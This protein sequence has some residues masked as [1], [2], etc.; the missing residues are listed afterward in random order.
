MGVPAEPRPGAAS[1]GRGLELALIATALLIGVGVAVVVV[2]PKVAPQVQFDTAA[3][4]I[5]FERLVSGERLEAFVTTTPKPFLTVLD[6]LLHRIGGW[7]AVSWMAMVG[8]G[9]AVA[10]AALLALRLGGWAA[11]GFVALALAGNAFLLVEAAYAYG[12]PWAVA[13][14]CLAGLLLASD[15]PRWGWAGAALLAAML[16]RIETVAIVAAACLVLVAVHVRRRSRWWDATSLP[17]GAWLLVFVPALALPIMLVHDWLLTGDPMFWASVA[18]R[19]SVS[20]RA[21]AAVVGPLDVAASLGFLVAGQPI[22]ALLAG[23]GVAVALVRRR[24]IGVVGVLGVGL[25]IAASL[26]LL[27]VRGTYVSGRYVAPIELAM[28]FGAG[29]AVGAV[30]GRILN[31]STASAGSDWRTALRTVVAP[32][33]I[34]A[35]LGIATTVPWGPFDGA[36]MALISRERRVQ[37]H[38]AEVAGPIS[39]VLDRLPDS[40]TRPPP[41]AGVTVPSGRPVVLFVPGLL[42]PRMAVDLRLPVDRVAAFGTAELRSPG[43]VFAPGQ[44]VYHDRSAG[45]T[46]KAYGVLEGGGA[47]EWDGLVFHPVVTNPEAGYW[48][49]EIRAG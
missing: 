10:L 15:R 44:V 45:Q 30:M 35:L 29:L 18:A 48:V 49:W 1:P 38:A 23:I 12:V 16:I 47:F 6:G 22:I 7:T 17:R 32:A 11:A 46:N 3:S 2:K 27:S 4:V 13:L 24:W 31:G 33:L 21:R 8:H 40:R 34:G 19:Y 5:H 36:T 39:A 43:D 20:A 37:A 26:V 25:G 42:R 41:P 14:W 28:L 9:L